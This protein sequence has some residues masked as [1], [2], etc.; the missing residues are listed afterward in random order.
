MKHRRL[1]AALVLPLWL[2]ACAVQRPPAA[3]SAPL[4]AQWQAPLPHGGQAA[5]LARWWEQWNDPLLGELI[6]AAQAVSP[7]LASAGSRLAQARAAQG[8]AESRLAPQID[9]TLAVSRGNNLLP[10][11]L[12]TR[13]Q[14]GLQAA[15]ELD[16]FGAQREGVQASQA[17][18]AGAEALDEGGFL[19]L[20]PHRHGTD[21]FFAA[22]WE[23]R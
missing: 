2:G 20:W 19:R 14:G 5:D 15:W 8:T 6:A 7:T 17:R 22:V 9:A 13:A 12:S 18:V 16:L 11:P 3:V 1:A 21:G 23:R 4:P 10:L